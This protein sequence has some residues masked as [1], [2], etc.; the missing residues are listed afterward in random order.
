MLDDKQNERFVSGV[1]DVVGGGAQVKLDD[2]IGE[3]SFDDFKKDKHGVVATIFSSTA[4]VAVADQVMVRAEVKENVLFLTLDPAPAATVTTRV[5][6][7]ID[8]DATDVVN[9]T[10]P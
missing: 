10:T 5:A 4:S 7:I 6:W 8:T 9:P 3:D 1:T 2:Q